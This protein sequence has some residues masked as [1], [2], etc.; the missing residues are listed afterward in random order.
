[1]KNKNAFTLIELL[2]V[3]SIIFVLVGLLLSSISATKEQSKRIICLNNLK[4]LQLSWLIYSG[5]NEGKVVDNYYSGPLTYNWVHGNL[6]FNVEDNTNTFLLVGYENSKL[7]SYTQNHRIYKCPSDKSISIHNSKKYPRVRSYSLN[8]WVGGET[9]TNSYSDLMWRW[10]NAT[11]NQNNSFAYKVFRKIDNFNKPSEIFSFVDELDG[12]I[13]DGQ[14]LV[15]IA[16][17]AFNDKYSYI[18]VNFPTFVHNK[19]GAFAF[20]DGHV[21]NHKWLDFRTYHLSS[22]YSQQTGKI[23]R[24]INHYLSKDVEWMMYHS[25]ENE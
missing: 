13:D 15:D 4:N 25:T 10:I 17:R 18:I 12:S 21:E 23:V 14:F 24:P 8:S 9:C 11:G 22:L 7:G 1:M 3:F 20:V 19:K 2:V 6:A 5:D 16:G